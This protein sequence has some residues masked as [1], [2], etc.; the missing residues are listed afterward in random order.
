MEQP[1]STSK[2][3]V[4]YHDP[5]GLYRLIAPGL[6]ARLPLRHLHWQSHSGPLRSIDTLHVELVPAESN[7]TVTGPAAAT[8]QIQ[9]G[10]SGTT[11][12]STADDGFQTATVG[13]RQGSLE[14]TTT[15]TSNAPSSSTPRPPERRHQI[16]GLRRTPYLKLLLVRCDDT[17]TYKSQTRSEI[18]DWVKKNTSPASSGSSNRKASIAPLENHDAFDWMIVHVVLP[19]S[20]A[21][22]QPRTSKASGGGDGTGSDSATTKTTSRWGKNSSTLLERLR[23]DFNTAADSKSTSSGGAPASSAA[24]DRVSQIRV[25]VD[26]VPY[27]L[28]PRV[29][30]TGSGTTPPTGGYVESEREAQA[31]WADVVGKLKSRI[32]A[33]FDV[34]VSQ[35]EDDIREKDVQRTLPGWNFCTF[36]ILKEGLARGFESVGLVDDALVGYDELS[37]GLDTVIQEQHALTASTLL[38]FTDDLKSAALK[39]IR[40]DDADEPVNLQAADSATLAIPISATKKPYRDLILANNVSVFDFRCY[41]FARQIAL[42]LRLGNAW[43]TREE[44]LT[45]LQEQQEATMHFTPAAAATHVASSSSSSRSDPENLP[46]LAEIC[47]RTL[48]FVPAVSQVMREDLLFS[49]ASEGEPLLPSSRQVIDNM[50]ASFAF[51][52]AQQILAQ[53]STTALP[54][55]PSSMSLA[56]D[57]GQ[58]PKVS[59]PEPKTMMHPARTSSLETRGHQVGA[60]MGGRAPPSPGI[61]PGPGQTQPAAHD[62]E[63]T[64]FLKA[65]LEDLAARR[66]D[67]YMLARN[68]LLKIGE[69]RGWSDGW[70]TAPILSELVDNHDRLEEVSLDDDTN[71]GAP[72]SSSR[73][74]PSPTSPS[75]SNV[76]AGVDDL[77]LRTAVESDTNFFRMY[78]VL[79]DKALRHYTVAGHTHAVNANFADLAVLKYHLADYAAAAANFYETTP[80]FGENSWN[81]LELSMLLMYARCLKELGHNDEY[82]WRLLKFLVKA[83]DAERQRLEERAS[84]GRVKHLTEK[85]QDTKQPP[86]SAVQGCLADLLSASTSV[87]GEMRVPLTNF[88]CVVAVDG[89][90]V[91]A[92]REDSFSVTLRLDSLLVDA[93]PVDS[94]RVRLTQTS[95][96]GQAREIWLETTDVCTLAPGTGRVQLHSRTIVPG[97]Y[98]IDQIR[99]A[100]KN[101]VLFHD[102][103]ETH[104][105]QRLSNVGATTAS[106]SSASTS[107]NNK[108]ILAE[109]H[110]VLYQRTDALDVQLS[111]SKDLQLDKNNFLELALITGWNDIQHCEMHIRAATGGLRLITTEA[112]VLGSTGHTFAKPVEAGFV[113][114]DDVP[115]GTSLAISFPFSIEQD[116]LELCLKV[117]VTYTTTRGTTFHFSKVPSVSTSLA[118]GVNV[119]DVFKHDALFSRFTVSTAT[120]SPLR[121]FRSELLESDMFTAQL[122]TDALEDGSVD[123]STSLPVV[124]PKQ[125]VS[126]LYKIVRKPSS[127]PL[128]APPSKDTKRTMYIKLHYSVFQDQLDAALEASLCEAF[129]KTT[130]LAQF[131]KLASSCVLRHVHASLSPYDLEKIALLNEMTT[132]VLA[133]VNWARE[134]PGLGP[135]STGTSKSKADDLAAVIYD[136]QKQH[137]VLAIPPADPSSSSSIRTILIPVD[138]PSITIVHTADIQLQGPFGAAVAADRFVSNDS[139]EDEDGGSDDDGSVSLPIFCVNQLLPAT[140]HL[141]W[142]R[143]WDT[144][145]ADASPDSSVPASS[146]LDDLEFS[147]EVSAPTDAWLI[148]GRRKGHFVIPAPDADGS[149]IGLSSTPALEAAIPLMLIPLREGRLPYPSVEIRQIMSDST[150]TGGHHAEPSLNGHPHEP[151]AGHHHCETDYR[152]L[153]ETV[154]VVADRTRLTLSLDASGP[155][156]GPLVLESERARGVGRVVV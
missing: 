38:S 136:W 29:Q 137:A 141:R 97:I 35:Y 129:R 64:R 13:G 148:G 80:F 71:S 127:G 104:T 56:S 16:P 93:L 120:A 47:R 41:I 17:D 115:A 61:F 78:E 58:E 73:S 74:P 89:P 51:S 72:V 91:F 154:H 84:F 25:G 36:F 67:L 109:P 4:E 95:S 77:L 1:F 106:A 82:A 144:G 34:R 98:T 21:Y 79:T 31:A 23:S 117:D 133:H 85:H 132:S 39:A 121:V 6:L 83:A 114:F 81:L 134:F 20:P 155:G 11:D 102:H 26:D 103:D 138:I 76:V 57:N 130:T 9:P 88:F 105:V 142:T 96:R 116:V 156:G 32:L 75:V 139:D 48:E 60:G 126:L 33:S 140:L 19:N 107:S 3:T 63:E 10:P 101:L 12:A 30:S 128:N 66:A 90:P 40:G 149:T 52:I 125:P 147:F 5:H 42:L 43:V 15:T 8:A 122:G 150:T 113:S 28:L 7:P 59:I 70:P 145:D 37:V 22:N 135:S 62:A 108:N 44:L 53:T 24:I 27:E 119:Q 50:V 92:D 46:M 118:L 55:P 45:K 99:I 69:K 131:A 111:T 124:F 110:L 94:V 65:G 100:S 153:G 151:L 49:L 123:H 152:N 86:I 112:K 2:V 146:L 143:I 18:R 68:I 87:S 54:I 14:S